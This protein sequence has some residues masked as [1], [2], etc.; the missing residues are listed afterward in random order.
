MHAP[1]NMGQRAHP[2]HFVLKLVS[3]KTSEPLLRRPLPE[4]VGCHQQ[5][6]PTQNWLP[7][8]FPPRAESVVKTCGFNIAHFIRMNCPVLPVAN[9][10]VV[11]TES[12]L[13][14]ESVNFRVRLE[15]LSFLSW[16]LIP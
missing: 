11:V 10:L 7:F 5:A 1:H 12:G 3:R 14:N 6:Y 2:T 15:N 4:H 8:S 13:D 9:K 16:L